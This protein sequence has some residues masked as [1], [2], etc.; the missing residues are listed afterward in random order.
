MVK[1]WFGGVLEICEFVVEVRASVASS[2]EVTT[3]LIFLQI[4]PKLF[5]ILFTVNM[6]RMDRNSAAVLL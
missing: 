1:S 6:L 3:F 4:F 2:C 5:I